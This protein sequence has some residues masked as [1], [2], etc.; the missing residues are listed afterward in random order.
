MSHFSLELFNPPLGSGACQC[1]LAKRKRQVRKAL[2][3]AVGTLYENRI[4]SW[5]Q[6]IRIF[7]YLLFIAQPRECSRLALSRTRRR[8]PP[9]GG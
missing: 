4:R 5:V 2:T 1:I 6:G 8:L 3:L 9:G 7:C